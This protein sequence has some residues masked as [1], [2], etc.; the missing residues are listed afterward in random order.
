M[1][2]SEFSNPSTL[3]QVEGFFHKVLECTEPFR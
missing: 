3:Q 2:E 1:R